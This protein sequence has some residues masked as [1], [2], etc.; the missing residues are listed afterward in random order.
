MVQDDGDL[1]SL[2]QGKFKYVTP[3]IWYNWFVASFVYFGITFILP[4]TLNDGSDS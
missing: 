4:L 1:K 3:I 2:F